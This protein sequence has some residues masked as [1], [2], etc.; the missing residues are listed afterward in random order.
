[1][2]TARSSAT[3]G[4]GRRDL[5]E[6]TGTVGHD[7]SGPTDD[8]AMTRSQ[9][10]LRVATE[11]REA[12]RARLRKH[13]VTEHQQVTVPAERPVVDTGAVAVELEQRDPVGFHRR[14]HRRPREQ[15]PRLLPDREPPE[16]PG[17]MTTTADHCENR[18]S[19]R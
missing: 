7:T 17:L 12:G 1:M 2:P 13:V 11:T 19:T 10:Q 15:R 18:R 8:D 3:S 14:L 4:H 5:V 16:F 9:E 6:E